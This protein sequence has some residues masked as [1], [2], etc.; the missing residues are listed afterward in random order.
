MRRACQT[1][2]RADVKGSISGGRKALSRE[3]GWDRRE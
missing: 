2:G 3:G 1:R